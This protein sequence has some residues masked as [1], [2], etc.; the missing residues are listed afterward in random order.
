MA[1]MPSSARNGAHKAE[2]NGQPRTPPM[3]NQNMAWDVLKPPRQFMKAAVPTMT[4]Y[5]AKLDGR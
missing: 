5:M 1:K 2:A 3:A 4:M